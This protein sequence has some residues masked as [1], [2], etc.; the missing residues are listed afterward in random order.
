MDS[1]TAHHSFSVRHDALR[2]HSFQLSGHPFNRTT[3]IAMAEHSLIE[4][5]ALSKSRDF[6]FSTFVDKRAEI[7][8]G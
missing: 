6:Q 4:E 5:D 7:V 3:A 8:R 2:Q 1:F